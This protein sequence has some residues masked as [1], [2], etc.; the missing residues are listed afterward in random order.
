MF[1][2]GLGEEKKL[3]RLLL[4]GNVNDF[5]AYSNDPTANPTIVSVVFSITVNKNEL[6]RT[7]ACLH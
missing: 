6:G 5:S 1:I 4:V 3:D 2:L 7:N